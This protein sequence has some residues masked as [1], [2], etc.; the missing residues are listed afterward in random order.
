MEPRRERRPAIPGPS[1]P[2]TRRRARIGRGRGVAAIKG[3]FGT[4]AGSTVREDGECGRTARRRLQ[5]RPSQDE[6]TRRRAI[7]SQV[8]SRPDRR[9]VENCEPRDARATDRRLNAPRSSV[10]DHLGRV[11]GQARSRRRLG[12]LWAPEATAS[13]AVQGRG[14]P[15]V[16]TPPERDGMTVLSVKS[17]ASF[18][19]QGALTACSH[20]TV[21][22][23]NGRRMARRH[24]LDGGGRD[25]AGGLAIPITCERAIPCA[26]EPRRRRVDA[27]GIIMFVVAEGPQPLSRAS[28]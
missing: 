25:R 18:A 20:D 23:S 24:G 19:R 14:A 11:L 2:A 4:A 16:S 28:R 13:S 27:K 26:G 12:A 6:K 1:C 15:A 17:S 8:P 21:P 10:E 3:D 7:L 5:L 9:I 22:R